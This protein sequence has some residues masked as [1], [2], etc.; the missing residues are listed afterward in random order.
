MTKRTKQVDL[1]SLR[2]HLAG[3]PNSASVLVQVESLH[4]TLAAIDRDN[5]EESTRT[6]TEQ[7]MSLESQ[8]LAAMAA[9]DPVLLRG[10]LLPNLS[11]VL[12]NTVSTASAYLATQPGQV[13]A[14]LDQLADYVRQIVGAAGS[15]G[16]R[17]AALDIESRARDLL[18]QVESRAAELADAGAKQ[19]QVLHATHVEYS[20]HLDEAV[21]KLEATRSAMES[22]TAKVAGE[23]R[24]S[25]EVDRAEFA[26]YLASAHGEGERL[27]AALRQ[28]LSITG[29]ESLSANYGNQAEREDRRSGRLRAGAIFFGLLAV[30]AAIVSIV[31]QERAIGRRT[32]SEIWSLWPG[33]LAM[34]GALAALAGYLGREA[35][36]HRTYA[37]DLRAKQLQLHNLGPY[38]N[39]LD[40]TV[41]AEIR[42]EL[43]ER[44]FGTNTTA[45]DEDAPTTV[46]SA[47]H[48][49]EIIRLVLPKVVNS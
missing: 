32:N 35:S 49:M 42:K 34:I 17:G 12:Q 18:S 3:V 4:T 26:K 7:L 1:P 27:I 15:A 16:D 19:V 24:K 2:E 36:R 10:A 11:S 21:E 23:V 25:L 43:V 40:P 31:L 28:L 20:I 13:V 48:L 37:Q 6:V 46:A 47:E 44:F 14:Y 29:D 9:S 38:L 33:K 45:H 5:A 30:V 8:L 39:E 22:D 41:Q